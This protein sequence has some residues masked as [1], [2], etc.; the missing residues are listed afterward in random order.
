MSSCSATCLG[1]PER[2]ATREELLGA[3][4]GG[5]DDAAGR[6]YLRQALYRLREVLPAELGPVQDGDVFHA[7]GPDLAMGTAQRAT[8]LIAQAGRQDGEVRLQ[9]LTRVVEQCGEAVPSW[10][11]SLA[12]G[13]LSVA[14]SLNDELISAARWTQPRSPSG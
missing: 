6:S 10:P 3:L 13:S 7:R 4:F 14:R 12:S 9:T 2:R 8:D 1:T 11:P 5:R